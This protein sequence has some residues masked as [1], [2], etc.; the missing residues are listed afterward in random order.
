VTHAR[1]VASAFVLLLP[2]VWWATEAV[3]RWFCLGW[4]GNAPHFERFYAL[5]LPGIVVAQ[6][7]SKSPG[8]WYHEVAAVTLQDAVIA[9]VG[10]LALATLAARWRSWR[11]RAQWRR[12]VV[13]AS[14]ALPWLG[15]ASDFAGRNDF[16]APA[17]LAL[18]AGY[19]VGILAA[20]LRPVSVGMRST[21]FCV[22][23]VCAA[24]LVVWRLGPLEP[25]QWLYAGNLLS[26]LLLLG[27]VAVKSTRARSAVA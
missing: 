14:L 15:A 11:E 10:S 9:V 26:S 24:T 21:L 1:R 20:I 4:Q 6:W 2:A 5:Y 3:A 8:G 23:L 12:A 25:V 27:L 13:V 16:G 18:L 22:A 7:F 17:A 19:F